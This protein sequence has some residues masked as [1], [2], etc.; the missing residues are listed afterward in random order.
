MSEEL[1]RL[2]GHA[3]MIAHLRLTQLLLCTTRVEAAAVCVEAHA[4][5]DVLVLQCRQLRS[6]ERVPQLRTEIRCASGGL[7]CVR[8]ESCAPYGPLVSRVGAWQSHEGADPVAA[9]SIAQHRLIIQASGDE[10]IAI[11]SSIRE[12]QI[13]N[14]SA[15]ARANNLKSQRTA[16][17]TS[18]E[19][20]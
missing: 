12:R 10:E 8:I 20:Q 17:A 2:G 15:V 9:R 3:S 18:R 19:P 6:A 4:L 13:G 1:C 16:A 7:R 14:G 11:G 5:D